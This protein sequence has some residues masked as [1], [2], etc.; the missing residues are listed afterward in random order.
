MSQKSEPREIYIGIDNGVGDGAL[1]ALDATHNILRR[2]PLPN[3]PDEQGGN[4]L[5]LKATYALIHA[6]AALANGGPV[7]FVLERPGGAQSA[8]AYAKM[9][10]CYETLRTI[11]ILSQLGEFRVVNPQMW[12]RGPDSLL[13]AAKGDTKPAALRLARKLWPADNFLASSRCHVPHAG[14]VDAALIA[15]YGQINKLR[16]NDIYAGKKRK[17]KGRSRRRRDT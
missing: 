9:H 13:N 5:D 15:Y 16:E 3:E 1:C 11:C 10:G 4:R 17:R 2:D 12:Q 7:T 14:M 6:H 8:K